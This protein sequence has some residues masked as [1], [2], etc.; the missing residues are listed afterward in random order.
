MSKMSNNVAIQAES[1]EVGKLGG[2]VSMGF[3]MDGPT[4]HRLDSGD[5]Q[6]G[7]TVKLLGF[8]ELCLKEVPFV[9]VP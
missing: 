4:T 8:I 7:L 2:L 1:N 3:L 5:P 9:S 6:T